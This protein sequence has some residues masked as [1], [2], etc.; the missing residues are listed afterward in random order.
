[1]PVSRKRKHPHKR[2]QAHTKPQASGTLSVIH[3]PV[4]FTSS[5]LAELNL[6]ST[7]YYKFGR[8][9]NEKGAAALSLNEFI[10]EF[11]LWNM[12]QECGDLPYLIAQA[13][14]TQYMDGYSGKA[15]RDIVFSEVRA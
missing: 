6:Y 3:T 7:D 4:S 12:E 10:E 13:Q 8:R 11:G 5:E 1:M 9:D 2:K 14:H 15:Y